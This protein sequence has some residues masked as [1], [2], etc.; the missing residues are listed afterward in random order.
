[1]DGEIDIN[2][3]TTKREILFADINKGKAGTIQG[4]VDDIKNLEKSIIEYRKLSYY[5]STS[6]NKKDEDN[7]RNSQTSQPIINSESI[8][9]ISRHSTEEDVFE[10]RVIQNII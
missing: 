7:K 1:L 10:L 3:L 6:Y 9:S 8:E 2:E 4:I 5:E